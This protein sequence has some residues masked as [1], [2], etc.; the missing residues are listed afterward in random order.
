VVVISSVIQLL[1]TLERGVAVGDTTL[2]LPSGSQQIAIGVV[3]I[4][5]LLFRPAGIMGNRE[6]L[7]SARRTSAEAPVAEGGNRNE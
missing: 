6:L 4:V 7:L 2:A 5:I 1:R 3:M